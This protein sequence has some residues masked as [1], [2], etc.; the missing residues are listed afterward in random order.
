MSMLNLQLNAVAIG[1]FLLLC[2]LPV[3]IPGFNPPAPL[4]P[5]Q[6]PTGPP[7]QPGQAGSDGE[8]ERTHQIAKY[9]L[10]NSI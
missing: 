3:S 5:A 10:Y 7:G 1:L 9:L 2:V 8:T 4:H 6:P